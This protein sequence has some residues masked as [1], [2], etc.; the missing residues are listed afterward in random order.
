VERRTESKEDK[1]RLHGVARTQRS[2]T[3]FK[4]NRESQGRVGRDVRQFLAWIRKSFHPPMPVTRL[5]VRMHHGD[6][7]EPHPIV[8]TRPRMAA[9]S[10]AWMI[11][12][13]SPKPDG[14]PN[15]W[16]GR[17]PLTA[18][19]HSCTERRTSSLL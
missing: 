1:E 9:D 2:A 14:V 8:P 7:K 19:R 18:R 10:E 16:T 3:H 15:L 6:D 4:T 17:S 12:H 5:T 11:H 13:R